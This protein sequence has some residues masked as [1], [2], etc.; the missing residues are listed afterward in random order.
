MIKKFFTLLLFYSCIIVLPAQAAITR[1]VGPVNVDIGGAS[2][3]T[4]SLTG[5]TIGRMIVV[6]VGHATNPGN[7]A[8]TS[9]NISGEADAT[10]VTAAN[11]AANGDAYSI[12]YLANN[13]AGGDKTITINFDANAFGSAVA[14]EYQG[15]DPSSQP[16]ATTVSQ[17][18]IT[19]NPTISITTVTAGDLILSACSSNGG[20]PTM[21]SG[22]SDLVLPNPG[23]YGNA[24][25]NVA[26]GGAGS[27]TL[28]WTDVIDTSWGVNAVAFKAAIVAGAGGSRHR[29][30]Q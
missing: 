24:A 14:V 21:P 5:T 29:V 9:V 10:R 27:K 28:I 13:T 23:Y 15:Q 18:G 4:L 17:T 25:D 7:G 3:P 30:V 19:G 8:V 22:Y 2:N 20:K 16:D 1:G 11:L 12:W 6:V 26:V